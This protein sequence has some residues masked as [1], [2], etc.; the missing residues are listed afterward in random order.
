[1]TDLP[2][3]A[4][5]ARFAQ[6]LLDRF[7]AS[8]L[9]ETAFPSYFNSFPPAAWLAWRR[10]HWAQRMLNPS[11][12]AALD[13]GSGLGVMLPF[14]SRQFGRVVAAD[15]DTEVTG[16][17]VEQLGLGSSVDVVEQAGS[18]QPPQRF[19]AIVA[20][21]VLEHVDDLSAIYDTLL[22]LTA[23]GGVWVIS[24]PTENLLYRGARAVARTSGEGHVRT[25][26]DV[27][28]GVPDSMVLEQ[29]RRLPF[30]M[31]LFL[32]GRFGRRP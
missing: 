17:M 9:E 7:G 22:P 11:G 31:P 25:I 13:F 4:E 24:G 32:V 16:F 30:G 12:R 6:P 19:D 28:D 20:L 26:H 27:F 3:Q 8:R 14:L 1:M 21:D 15:L 18:L 29:R 2:G 23:P 10:V 5:F